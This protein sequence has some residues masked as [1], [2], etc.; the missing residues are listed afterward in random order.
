MTLA[1]IVWNFDLK[2]VN[3]EVNWFDKNTT[4]LLWQ[5]PDYQMYLTPRESGV[6]I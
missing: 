1:R 2:L 3:P 6:K 4:Y 5:K